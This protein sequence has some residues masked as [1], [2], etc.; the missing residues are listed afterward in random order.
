MNYGTK[1][2]T[3]LLKDIE[4]CLVGLISEIS[5]SGRVNFRPEV[6][7]CA[8]KLL[9][10]RIET[11]L[12]PLEENMEFFVFFSLHESIIFKSHLRAQLRCKG[13]V[14]SI[15]D[16]SI[17]LK[18]TKELLSL[19]VNGNIE[20][21]VL[22]LDGAIQLNIDKEFSIFKAALH[23]KHLEKDAG[24]TG[25]EDLRDL[26]ELF[27]I[28]NY[29]QVLY[30]VFEKFELRMI[31]EQE[32]FVICYQL[33]S[34]F[35]DNLSEV[36]IKLHDAKEVLSDI[37]RKLYLESSEEWRCLEVLTTMRDSREL[38]KFILNRR[39]YG[40]NDTFRSHFQFIT[41]QLQS[42]NYDENVLNNLPA[43]VRVLAPFCSIKDSDSRNPFK[44]FMESLKENSRFE[45]EKLKIVNRHMSIVQRWFS[46]SNVS[47]CISSLR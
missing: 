24:S 35:K 1:F 16:F 11:F 41:T 27:E 39:F 3:A 12:K 14:Y 42:M 8:L 37:R 19:F 22:T 28:A 34:K 38:F 31:T 6:K 10:G 9:Y 46:T 45:M 17:G 23:C 44:D 2:S 5:T 7:L 13:T 43:A 47:H 40:E 21:N 4:E 18:A 20:Y 36:D 25:Y 32:E 30:E 33:A 26:M 15:E 29:V